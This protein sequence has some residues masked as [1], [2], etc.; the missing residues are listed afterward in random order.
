MYSEMLCSRIHKQTH[1]IRYARKGLAMYT[2]SECGEYT[3]NLHLLS[4]ERPAMR[5]AQCGWRCGFRPCTSPCTYILAGAC[6]KCM[7]NLT[8]CFFSGSKSCRRNSGYPRIKR[9][10]KNMAYEWR[11]KRYAKITSTFFRKNISYICI[12]RGGEISAQVR[13]L[14]DRP[15]EHSGRVEPWHTPAAR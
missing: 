7:D 15:G 12:I 9:E 2:K 11:T 6:W 14:Y 10:K 13:H 5:E 8:N 4:W 3:A 1:S